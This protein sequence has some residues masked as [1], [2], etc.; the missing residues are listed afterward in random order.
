MRFETVVIVW[1]EGHQLIL[2]A[3]RQRNSRTEASCAAQ[4]LQYPVPTRLITQTRRCLPLGIFPVPW[5]V[6]QVLPALKS[7]TEGLHRCPE[8]PSCDWD[9]KP[10]SCMEPLFLVMF[11]QLCSSSLL[12]HRSVGQRKTKDDFNIPCVFQINRRTTCNRSKRRSAHISCGAQ[13]TSM[14]WS[15]PLSPDT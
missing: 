6:G 11:S 9:R 2:L 4:Q 14:R 15:A 12:V 8:E 5:H 3:C 1:D 7:K 13:L 10:L